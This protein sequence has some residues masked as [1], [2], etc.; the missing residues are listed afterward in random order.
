[1][2]INAYLAT[3]FFSESGFLWTDLVADR[4]RAST[5]I[6]L[7]VPQ[8]NKEIN[9]KEANDKNITAVKIADGDNQYLE[10]ANILIACLDG[11]EIDSGVSAEIGYY[12]GLIRTENKLSA[13]PKIRTIIGIYTDIRRD[14]SGD[15]RFY[16]NLY[17]KGLVEK[18]GRIVNS[19]DELVEY[20]K[21]IEKTILDEVNHHGGIL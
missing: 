20:I 8:E 1:M 12:S 3:N 10:K 2:K 11:V 7:Y 4:V 6:S 14:G 21:E 15:N 19:S 13:N 9:D 5:G 18:Y 17:T 16:I